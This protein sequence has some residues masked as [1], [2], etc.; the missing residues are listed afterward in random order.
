[1]PP[2]P[3]TPATARP[4]AV[5]TGQTAGELIV[6]AGDGGTATPPSA[7]T[8]TRASAAK[9][10]AWVLLTGVLGYLAISAVLLSAYVLTEGRGFFIPMTW[11]TLS[12]IQLF[13]APT[14]LAAFVPFAGVHMI[15]TAMKMRITPRS[16]AIAGA[17]LGAMAGWAICGRQGCF[18]P[19]GTY[20]LL[21]WYI[22]A[23]GLFSALFYQLNARKHG[24]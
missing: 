9:H 20:P 2:E 16:A 8:T 21:G 14:F 12:F 11:P 19:F 24:F 4:P 1:M 17:A 18:G 13:A 23:C 5:P 22:A 6:P 10:Y 7:S 15:A 3:P